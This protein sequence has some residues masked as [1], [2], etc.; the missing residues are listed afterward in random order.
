LIP[1]ETAQE[2][3]N[4][5]NHESSS[6]R[7]GVNVVDFAYLNHLSEG[8]EKNKILHDLMVAYGDDVWN[9]AFFLTRQRTLADDIRQD[10]FLK[11]YEKMETFRG[12]SSVINWLLTITRNVA[13]DY[14]KKA[15][16]RKVTLIG[17]IKDIGTYV[18][19]EKEYIENQ[20]LGDTW[21]VVLNLPVKLREVLVLY[22]HHGLSL[23]E[24][25][26]LLH[27]SESA[28]KVRLHRARKKVNAVFQQREGDH[29]GQAWV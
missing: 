11:A 5:L 29:D 17:Y 23:A 1:P 6:F 21:K 2:K 8:Y 3:C 25:S 10:V 16:F 9:F 26:T 19:A 12:Q 13:I 20:D 7:E 4:L 18:S 28:T 15:F 14:Q 24:I 22:A 27:I